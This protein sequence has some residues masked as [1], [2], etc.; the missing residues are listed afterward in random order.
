MINFLR[1]FINNPILTHGSH[2]NSPV[3]CD[4]WIH[5]LIGV[6]DLRPSELSDVG[7]KEEKEKRENHVFITHSDSPNQYFG[8]ELASGW[9]E[10]LA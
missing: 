5:F 1:V 7:G 3:S 9:P 10:P 8:V 6:H 4:Y 2:G